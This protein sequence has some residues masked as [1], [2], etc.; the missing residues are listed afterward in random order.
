MTHQNGTSISLA[1]LS[2]GK[3]LIF[4][5]ISFLIHSFIDINIEIDY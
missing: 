3:M 2:F 4:G 5:A 1:L